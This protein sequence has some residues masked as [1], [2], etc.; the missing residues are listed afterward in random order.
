MPDHFTRMLDEHCRI[1]GDPLPESV[2]K[3][4]Q[5]VL[6]MQ[7]ILKA[8]LR[9]SGQRFLSTLEDALLKIMEAVAFECRDR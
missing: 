4:R 9:P 2:L 3:V 5:L 1:A 6:Q 8:D 7:E